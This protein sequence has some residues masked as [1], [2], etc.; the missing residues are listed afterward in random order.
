MFLRFIT[1]EIKSFLR[2][3]SLG[4]SIALRIFLGFLAAYFILTFFFLGIGLHP[5]LKEYF[6]D[7]K[8]LTLVNEFVL[9]WLVAELV[10]RFFMQTLPVLNIRPL[11]INPVPRS[12]TINYVLV[13]SLFSFYNILTPIVVI[14]FALMNFI[15]AEVSLGG[16][17]GWIV[18]ML[19]L[20]ASVNY[21]NFLLKKKFSDNLKSLLPYA[22]LALIVYVLEHFDIFSSSKLFAKAIQ[23]VIEIPLLSLIGVAIVIGMY[24]WNYNYLRKNFY[25][26]ASLKSKSERGADVD[27]SW[28][29][30]F[31]SIA[32]FLQLDLRLI[33][34]NKRPKS[35][36]TM[37]LIF[38]FYG[39][40]FYA[41]DSYSANSFMHI[42][43]GIF[44]TGIFV[45]N[46][47]QFIPAWDSSY[48]SMMMSQ[49]I[50]MRQY[51]ESK[52][53]LMY[54]SV[55]VMGILTIPYVYFGIEVLLLNLACALFNAG[56]NIPVILYA[57][58]F[59]KKAIMLDK[60][61]FMNYQGTGA[62]QWLV[63]LPILF[64]PM[65]IWI[66]I[67]YL[68]NQNTA[69]LVLALIG[70]IALLVRKPILAFIVKSYK[71]NKYAM[72]A[73]FKQQEN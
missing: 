8:P 48:Y 69:S 28:T 20:V 68:V 19:S 35:T 44:M 24:Y 12:K 18:L 60:S 5:L 50:P 63:G 31:G 6:P 13:K 45:I 21:A 33:M 59:N 43:V 53:G 2:S 46:F 36:V 9:L 55:V 30:R 61:P 14:P 47:G 4:K 41:M 17:I 66:P 72:I 23:Y 42:F 25:L 15:E 27:L 57:G 52:A 67:K 40:F 10:M 16:M 32:P 38:V 64:I 65:L 1:L 62:S 56:V 71:K 22:I 29:E 70:I 51:L 49:N 7:Q 73:G 54:V 34:R 3:A 11:L 26:D 37:S 39:L 58:S